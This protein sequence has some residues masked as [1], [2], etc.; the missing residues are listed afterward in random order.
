MVTLTSVATGTVQTTT[1]TETGAS[2]SSACF[3]STY[4]LTADRSGFKTYRETAIRLGAGDARGLDVRMEIGS[5]AETVTVQ[6]SPGIIQTETGAREGRLTAAQIDTLS[7]IGRSPLELLRMMPGVV[8]PDQNRLEVVSFG[9]AEGYTVNGI[10][11]SANTI[12]LDG[13]SIIDIG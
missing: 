9:G 13:P 12:S 3:P 5:R 8:A 1:T 2:R 6:S 7:S 10:R 11:S 4:D